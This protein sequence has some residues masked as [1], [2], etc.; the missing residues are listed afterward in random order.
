[1]LRFE[2][3]HEPIAHPVLF[4]RRMLGS[5]VAAGAILLTSLLF[6]VVGYHATAGLGWLDSLLNASMILAGMGPVSPLDEPAA[7]LFASFYALYSGVVF[8]IASGI[9]VAPALHRLLHQLHLERDGAD[10]DA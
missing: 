4:L 5:F 7:K 2:R 3:H 10:R 6:G 9:F 1:M 8:V